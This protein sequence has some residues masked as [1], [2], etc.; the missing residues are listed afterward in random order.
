MVN[1]TKFLMKECDEVRASK[2]ALL[3]W[4]RVK[5]VNVRVRFAPSPT[6]YMHV[7]NVRTALFN[8][9]YAKHEDG[10]F[11]LRIED[12]DINRHVG[13]AV[14][15]ITEG[16]SWLGIDW[17]EGPEVGG[18]Y[19]PY[20]QSERLNMYHAAAKDLIENDL[21]YPCVCEAEGKDPDNCECKQISRQIDSFGDGVAVRFKNTEGRSIFEDIV[22]GKMSFE[23][24]QFGDF[25]LIKSDGTPTYNFANVIDDNAMRITHVIRGDDHVSNTPR[26]L[27]VYEAFGYDPPKFAHLPQILGSDGSRLSKR[28]G[29][30]SLGEF[31]DKGFL[32]EAMMN[33]LALLGWSSGDEREFFSK[34]ELIDLFELERVKQ[35]PAQF[36]REKLTFLN[37]EHMQQLSLD[38]RTDIAIEYLKRAGYLEQDD[39]DDDMVNYVKK[40]V[41]A[42]GTRFKYGEQIEEYGAHFFQEEL[43]IEKDLHSHF[44]DQDVRSALDKA[45]DRF[46]QAD[47]WNEETVEN[48]IR[49]SAKEFDLKAAPLIHGTRVALSAKT[50][51]PSLFTLVVLVGQERAHKRIKD[52]L[53]AIPPQN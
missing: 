25:I 40:I 37:S 6:G 41:D 19:G 36:N 5:I 27:M 44:A 32:P 10:V 42:L 35:S 14:E 45:A 33:Y 7:G 29:A 53:N 24:H 43:S 38:Q 21:A 51:G 13:E 3:A 16:L 4:H 34:N 12:T 2:G 26:Q 23:N 28:H 39:I 31:R 8:W 9:L 46:L 15:T 22:Q 48:I 50:V 52:A 47:E 30:A 11:I 20:F 17:D 18:D 49:T 1:I